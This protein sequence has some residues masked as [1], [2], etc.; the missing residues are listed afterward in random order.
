VTLNDERAEGR[1]ARRDELLAELR[2]LFPGD[3]DDITILAM[4]MRDRLVETKARGLLDHCEAALDELRCVAIAFPDNNE[5][6]TLFAQGL[7]NMFLVQK[8]QGRG[9]GRNPVSIARRTVLLGELSCLAVAFPAEDEIRKLLANGLHNSLERANDKTAVLEEL[10]G[11]AKAFPADE[12]VRE[13]MARSLHV[14]INY[15][16][17]HGGALM[18]ELR[19]LAAAVPADRNVRVLL[20]DSLIKALEWSSD[21]DELDSRDESLSELRALTAA[22][23]RD[24]QVRECAARGLLNALL[25]TT[26]A[27]RSRHQRTISPPRDEL[28]ELAGNMFT[29]D[30]RRQKQV[31]LQIETLNWARDEVGPNRRAAL[32]A[33]LR[34][35]VE[36]EQADVAQDEMYDL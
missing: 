31:M 1:L 11:L 18:D 14:V 13:L 8:R 36:A 6:Q 10:R 20:A 33:E 26:P 32:L 19:E 29:D 4:G 30:Q 35:A 7:S 22:F 23:P 12:D 9:G 3:K 24:R 17:E 2:R 5:V 34:D 15:A 25:D 28:R 16:I 21:N 27:T